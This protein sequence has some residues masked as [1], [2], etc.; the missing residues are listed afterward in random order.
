MT[1]LEQCNFLWEEI[2]KRKDDI[3][4]LKHDVS[5]MEQIIATLRRAACENSTA[6]VQ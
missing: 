4:R 2:E 5:V 3:R 1:I 6:T